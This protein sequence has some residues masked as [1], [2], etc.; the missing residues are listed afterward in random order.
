VA[1]SEARIN[2]LQALYEYTVSLAQLERAVGQGW[3][4]SE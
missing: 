3:K 4:E 1:L 2:Y